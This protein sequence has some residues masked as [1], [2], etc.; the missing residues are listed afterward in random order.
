MIASA[1]H[2]ASAKAS[3]TTHARFVAM[4]PRIYSQA[5]MAFR[6]IPRDAKQEMIAEV[7]ANAF[8]AFLRLVERNRVD[9][10]FPTALAKYAIRQVRSGRC[11]GGRLNIHDVTSRYAQRAAGVT[12]VHL[13]ELDAEKGDW[14]EFLLEDRRA[15]PAETAAARIDVASW[16]RS[17]ARR[18]R[19]IAQALATGE[20]TAIVARYFGLTP[21]RVSQLR[22]E[23]K[24]D[25]EQFQGVPAS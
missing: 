11:V 21:G 24:A 17:L 6:H 13:E 16:L 14:R 22:R 9:R 4:L 2:T 20:A 3:A 8:C 12:V 7:V 1:C 18:K 25:W 10:I 19:R 23:L 15:G 5:R